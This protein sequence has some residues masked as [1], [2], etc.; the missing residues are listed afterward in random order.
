MSVTTVSMDAVTKAL[1]EATIDETVFANIEQIK[2]CY[3]IRFSIK[4]DKKPLPKGWQKLTNDRSTFNDP[5][6]G[7]IGLLS[8]MINYGDCVGYVSNLQEGR[9]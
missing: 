6:H 7:Y 1:T 8:H 2:A 4:A 3:P 9:Y 5:A